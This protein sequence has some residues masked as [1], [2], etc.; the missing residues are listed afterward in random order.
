MA[1]VLATLDYVASPLDGE[2]GDRTVLSDGWDSVER[3][4]RQF[5]M[6]IAAALRTI[7]DS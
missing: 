2:P 4:A 1:G 6:M 7:V 3:P 5:P